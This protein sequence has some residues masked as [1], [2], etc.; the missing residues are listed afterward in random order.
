MLIFGI[1]KI[2]E[3]KNETR[4]EDIHPPPIELH[5]LDICEGRRMSNVLNLHVFRVCKC[6]TCGFQITYP[7]LI[8][9]Q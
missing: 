7:V 6:K 9:K 2:D 4:L 8:M 5:R 3:M 1:V